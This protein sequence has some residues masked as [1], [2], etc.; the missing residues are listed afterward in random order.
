MAMMGVDSVGYH[1]QTV[2]GRSDD[3][4]IAAAAYYA[5]RGE[6]P[7]TWGG[8]GCG[9]LGLDGEVDLGDYRAI[10][11]ADGAH[12]PR[13][14]ARL[15]GCRRPG[16]ELVVSPHKSVAELGVIGRAE[17]MHAICDAER[18]VTLDYLDRVV[19]EIG[20]RR[21]RAQVATPTGGLIWATSRH[22]TTRA[23]DPQVHDHVLIANAVLMGDSHG[24]WKALDTAFVR[25]HLHAATAVGRLAA[26]AKAVE[27]GYGIV[28]DRGPSGRLGGWAITGIPVEVCEAHSKRAAQ[29]D[30]A[31]G[32][33]GSYA[34]RSVAARATRDRKADQPLQDLM[35][36]WQSELTALGYPPAALEEAVD[37]AGAAYWP[38]TLDLDELA[39]ELLAPGGRLASEKT[40]T[41]GD[42]IVAVAPHLH[43]LPMEY[44][45]HAVEAVLAHTEAVRLPAVPGAREP[46]WAA[47]CVLTDEERIAE[48]AE[49]LAGRKGAEVDWS[50]ACDAIEALQ[51]RLG[52][53]LSSTQRRV[54]MGLMTGG[55]SLDVIVGIAGSGKTT[56][57]SA[58]RA[59]YETAGYTVLGTAT[60]G[61]AAKTLGEGAGMES[62]TIASL[63]WR[64]EHGTLALTDRHVIICD[65][66]GM[67]TDVDLSRL[68][69][70]VERAAAKMIVVGDD[71]QLDA[72]GPGG[73]LTALI[74]R[75]PDRVWTLTDNL[76]QTLPAECA[77]LGELRDGNVAAAIGW[78]A[79][80]G[81]IHAV[82]NQRHAV[83]AMVKA[84]AAD[85]AAG[86]ETL[87]LAYRRDNVEALNLTARRLWETA[88]LLSGPELTAPG[89]RR[90]RTGDRIIT[91]A[92]GPQGAWVTSQAAQVTTVDPHTQQLTAVT[93]D[94]QRLRMG[95]DDIAA[96]RL[97]YG[98]AITAHRSQ[99]ST[100]DVAHVLDDGGG[101]ELAYVAMSR[102][103]TASHV[104]VT[105]TDPRQAAERL[106]WTWDQQRRQQW[107]TERAQDVAGLQ[108]DI[109]DLTCERD[110]LIRLI[111]PD[112]TDQI[113]QVHDQIAQ[114]ESDR[115]DLHAGAGFWAL[116]PVGRAHQVLEDA[117]RTYERDLARAQDR[118]L[119][120]WAQHRARQAEQASATAVTQANR[121]WQDTV[122]PHNNELGSQLDRL[123]SEARTLEAAQ[124]ARSDFLTAYPGVRVRIREID[125]AIA[126]QQH[127]LRTSQT[128][129]AIEWETPAPQPS[130]RHDPHLE[131]IHHQHVAQAMHAPQIG[132]P[133]I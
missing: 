18:D 53:P 111:P 12:H 61:Q 116:M 76:R 10:F 6:T 118:Y 80:A 51:A 109:A 68:L 129:P 42:V 40:F 89:G 133:G 20:G 91:L 123:G 57:L 17:H 75:H 21:G 112:V 103:R 66:S 97:G 94:G 72:V 45:D 126:Q 79:Q 77:A 48:L 47:R 86:Q 114:V 37:A 102:A 49:A 84:W 100:V 38:P 11:G 64:L 95:P 54:A 78:Y 71:R 73:A 23:G 14:G 92:P 65:E 127:Q 121:A 82:P 62:R 96:E 70:A 81:R 107:I 98:Y 44:L 15:V 131:H 74:A 106:A 93:P 27:L 115:S 101:R 113:A 43:G 33:A 28:A 108:R 52:A 1:E 4:V 29:I 30:A 63:T 88:G 105:A 5:S 128:R 39:A 19:S 3:P 119:G 26:A 122:R 41:R 120:L 35:F 16:L 34:A 99:G 104:Y 24:G 36:R 69:G 56:T 50:A 132:G 22:A 9:L 117:Q 8:Q 25:D 31:V 2:A 130:V 46:A 32:P 59:G 13:T 90:Y 124:Q 7:M 87:M 85:I 83:G 110:R 58:V 55:N 60:S 67:T 125:H